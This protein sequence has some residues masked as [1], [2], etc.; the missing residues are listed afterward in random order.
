MVNQQI[1]DWIKSQET[2][3]YS[4]QQIYSYLTQQGYNPDEVNEAIN[5]VAQ[6]PKPMNQQTPPIKKPASILPIFMISLVVIAVVAGG[7]FYFMFQ[8]KEAPNLNLNSNNGLLD[9][10]N[11]KTA[12]AEPA[13]NLTQDQQPAEVKLDLNCDAFPDK[14]DSCT[15]YKCQFVHPFTGEN[16]T[17]EILGIIDEKCNYVEQMPNN[18]KMECKYLESMRKAAAQY[19]KDVAGAESTGVEVNA[20]L[21][22]GEVK[23]RYTIDGK[24]V[25]NPLEEAMNDGQCVISGYG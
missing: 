25:A 19:Y 21:V 7:I 10:E 5:S 1:L 24:E 17:K 6:T 18:G 11:V 23:T 20:S 4:N 16:M 14:L 8:H 12:A 2:Q 13:V 22:S 3:G 9:Q 15:E